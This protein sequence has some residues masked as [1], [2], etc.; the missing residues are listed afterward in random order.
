MYSGQKVRILSEVEP[1]EASVQATVLMMGPSV[2]N[3]SS[4]PAGCMVGL[5]GVDQH[6][7]KTGTLT[8]CDTAMSFHQM[9]YTV[10]PVVRVAVSVVNAAHIAKLAEGLRRLSK[11]DPLVQTFLSSS[12]EHIVAGCGELHLE[13]CLKDLQDDFMKG[14][15]IKL[16]PPV[17]SYCETITAPTDMTCVAKSANKHNRVYTH[18]TSKLCCLFLL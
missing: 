7:L 15:P 5:V 8:T 17:V 3:V 13:I 6:L 12:G 9:K 14:C 11:S 10:A 18:N 4:F 1:K 2:E 16:S